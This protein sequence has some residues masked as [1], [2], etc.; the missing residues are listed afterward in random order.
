M[1]TNLNPLTLISIAGPCRSSR[2]I[3]NLHDVWSLAVS[4][5]TSTLE[6]NASTACR[7]CTGWTRFLTQYDARLGSAVSP[8]PVTDDM[9]RGVA[10]CWSVVFDLAEQWGVIDARYESAFF[11]CG[12]NDKLL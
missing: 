12:A 3:V 7:N 5:N 1:W 10:D 2:Y 9:N 8:G 6:Y 11:P 4:I